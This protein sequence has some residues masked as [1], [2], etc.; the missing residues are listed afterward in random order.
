MDTKAKFLF[1]AQPRKF[2]EVDQHFFLDGKKIA[3]VMKEA[4][5]LNG[6]VIIPYIEMKTDKIYRAFTRYQSYAVV[7]EMLRENGYPYADF[8]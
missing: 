1:K 5:N 2:G 8:R 6:Y 3:T 7:R 4:G